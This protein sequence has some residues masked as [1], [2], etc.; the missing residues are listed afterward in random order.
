MA[1]TLTEREPHR[2]RLL[3]VHSTHIFPASGIVPV[4]YLHGVYPCLHA[5]ILKYLHALMLA[6][7]CLNASVLQCLNTY[8]ALLACLYRVATLAGCN[9]FR[10]FLAAILHAYCDHLRLDRLPNTF[11]CEGIQ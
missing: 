7:A 11:L 4:L 10:L 9:T 8:A 3:H 5:S 6:Y 2:S 1:K